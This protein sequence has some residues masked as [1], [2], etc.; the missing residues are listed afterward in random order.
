MSG[1]NATAKVYWPQWKSLKLQNGC[2]YRFWESEDDSTTR[3]L[4]VVPGCHISEVLAEF[5]GGPNGGHLG[6]NKTHNKMKARFYWVG[7]RQSILEWVQSCRECMLT[8][9]PSTKNRGRMVLYNSGAPFER[10]AIDIAGLFPE[11]S[12]GNR[13]IPVVIDYFSKCAKVYAIPNQ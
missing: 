8:K 10:V 1:E 7:C 4:L 3:D 12:A 11:S 6:V 13:Y 2:L 9:G 5:H